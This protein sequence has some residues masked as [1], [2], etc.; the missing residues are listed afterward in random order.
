MALLPPSKM[1]SAGG[2]AP[3]LSPRFAAYVRD[4]LMDREVDPQP[5]F[6]A[7]GLDYTNNEEY[8][9]P[10]PLDSVAALF[11]RA[12]EVTNNRT[13]G[14]SMGRDFHYESSSVLIVAM[15]AAP[16]VGGGLAFLNQYDRYIDSGITTRFLPN[17]EPVVFS[18]DLMDMDSPD[19]AQLNEY[20][21][22]FL[23]QTLL[24][25][26]RTDVPL[27]R[28]TFRHKQPATTAALQDFFKCR[29]EFGAPHNAIY[30]PS[31]FLGQPFLT[32]NK[33]MFRVLA[34]AMDTYFSMGDKTS[35]FVSKVCRQIMLE[36]PIANLDS[37]SVARLMGLS[38]R[39]LRRRLSEE[40]FTFKEAKNLA[41]ER[42]AKYLLI[43]SRASLTEIAFDLGYSELSA[44]SRAFRSWVGESP[45]VYRENL[46][47]LLD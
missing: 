17:G 29:L 35:G 28:V 1:S 30:L 14:L 39:T 31:A 5:V 20:L 33:L 43:N 4:Y 21:V 37:N 2:Y 34:N 40:G 41:R 8:D 12:A 15:L 38:A 11:E 27:L 42:R 24:I 13:M 25:A 10:L 19:M 6:E 26:T 36:D 3:S 18:A 45:Q 32:C 47:A 22:G 44:F 46:R 16:S 9:L 23:V 7:S